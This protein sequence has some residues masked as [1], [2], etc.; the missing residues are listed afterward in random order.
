MQRRV[1]PMVTVLDEYTYVD[2]KGALF[3]LNTRNIVASRPVPTSLMPTGLVDLLTDQEVRDLI[4]Y[5]G[6]RR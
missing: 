3:K 2:A 1:L 4:A 6:S 5:L